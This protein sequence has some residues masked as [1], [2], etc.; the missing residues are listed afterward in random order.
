MLDYL[1][2][3]EITSLNGNVIPYLHQVMAK[4]LQ[5]WC[6]YAQTYFHTKWV[7]TVSNKHSSLGPQIMHNE[8]WNKHYIYP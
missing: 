8:P 4:N 3:H 7:M 5:H 2:G 1:S 6:L